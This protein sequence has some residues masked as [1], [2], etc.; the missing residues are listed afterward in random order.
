MV[1]GGEGNS[2]ER[3]CT[4]CLLYGQQRTQVLSILLTS[5]HKNSIL[6]CV[7]EPHDWR[8]DSPRERSVVFYQE[9]T[10]ET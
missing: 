5:S 2:G 1:V 8:E 4:P 9:Q 10:R 6:F 7:P 3:V